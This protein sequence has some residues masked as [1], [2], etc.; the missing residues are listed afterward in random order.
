M[1]DFKEEYIFSMYKTEEFA[2]LFKKAKIVSAFL[3]VICI[4]RIPSCQAL[5]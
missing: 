4:A 3:C 2:L 5:H 1:Q